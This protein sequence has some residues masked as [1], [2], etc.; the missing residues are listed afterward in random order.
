MIHRWECSVYIYI[1]FQKENPV[2]KCFIL[3]GR[4]SFIDE[5][6]NS[7]SLVLYVP[8]IITVQN[9]SAN[10][11][12][13]VYN[14]CAFMIASVKSCWWW[15]GERHLLCCLELTVEQN[16]ERFMTMYFLLSLGV[17]LLFCAWFLRR[18]KK[19]VWNQYQSLHECG[20]LPWPSTQATGV[21]AS[22]IGSLLSL[23]K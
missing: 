6:R 10:N 4:S 20:M 9:K 15:Q 18:G 8:I 22:H 12:D 17:T 2:M 19:C 21:T 13:T 7:T 5:T 14:F 1:Y 3:V 23:Q 16:R 11:M